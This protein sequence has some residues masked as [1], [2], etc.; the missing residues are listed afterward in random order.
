M[1]CFFGRFA[2]VLGALVLFLTAC[3]S[4]VPSDKEVL[5]SLTDGVI[6]PAYQSVTQ[7]MAQ[8]DQDVKV[9]C[10]APDDASLEAARQ[11]WHDARASWMRSEAMWFGPVMDRRSI[12]LI[13]WTPT[14]ASGIEGLLAE[15]CHIAVEEVRHVIA[16]NHRGFGAIE[17]ILFR[18][19]AQ[20]KPNGSD[21][22]CSYLS[23]LTE[24]A[25]EEADLV[26]L[27]WVEGTGQ[28]PAYRDYFT[29]RSKTAMLASSAVAEIVRTQVFLIRDIVDMRLASALGFRDEIPDLS[30]IPGGAADNGLQDLRHELLGM[31]AVYE[32]SGPDAPGLSALVRPLSEDADQRMRSQLAE[33][34]A[35]ID[36][37]EGP[38]RIAIAEHP[39]QVHSLYEQLSEVQQTIATEVV[40]LLG[41][42]VGFTDTDGDSLR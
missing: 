16:S 8:L 36:S 21:S 11:S 9:L 27:E 33:A 17:H 4:D 37:V 31:Q 10:N 39:E 5:I 41:V 20:D 3:T 34:I 14:D 6:V 30:A 40:S 35:A 22:R 32:G 2:P 13:D 19:N 7:D 12:S 26:L 42:S 23:A 18:S 25:R 28:Q 38:L 29:E 15:E 1:G 24:V